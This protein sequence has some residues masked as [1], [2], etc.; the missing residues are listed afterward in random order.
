[1]TG[2]PCKECD[3][4][5]MWEGKLIWRFGETAAFCG[6]L[7]M[8]MGWSVLAYGLLCLFLALWPD[9]LDDVQ[10]IVIFVMFLAVVIGPDLS[11]LS[12]TQLSLIVIAMGLILLVVGRVLSRSQ[13]VLQCNKCGAISRRQ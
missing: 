2:I 9:I 13:K 12:F 7:I 3:G 4:G 10:F 6:Y 1:M 8:V 11:V 5:Q